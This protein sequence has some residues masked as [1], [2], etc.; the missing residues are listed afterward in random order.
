MVN[1]RKDERIQKDEKS[2]DQN[3]IGQKFGEKSLNN[4]NKR[5]VIED[6]T[7]KIEFFTNLLGYFSNSFHLE[8]PR[9][10]LKISN[11][12]ISHK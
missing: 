10:A 6:V 2:G 7:F 8:P 11:T 9:T 12:L 5:P 4:Q 1:R 3:R